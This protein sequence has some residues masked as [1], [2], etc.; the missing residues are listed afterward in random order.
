[1]ARK[2]EK[3]NGWANYETWNVALWFGNDYGM[4]QAVKEHGAKFT[5]ASAE[6]FTKE[7]LP[8]GTPDFESRGG[9]KCYAKVNW[10]EI[11]ADFNEMRG[12]SGV[13]EAPARG[14]LRTMEGVPLRE[15]GNIYWRDIPTGTRVELV[16]H[17]YVVTLG[18]G[19]KKGA[20]WEGREAREAQRTLDRWVAR[21]YSFGALPATGVRQH[22]GMYQQPQMRAAPSPSPSSGP[23]KDMRDH[24]IDQAV[25]KTRQSNVDHAVWMDSH[26]EFHVDQASTAPWK[27]TIAVAHAPS[28]HLSYKRHG[29]S[30]GVHEHPTRPLREHPYPPARRPGPRPLPRRRS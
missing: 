26:G 22:V 2:A 23:R 19:E 17:S 29:A 18:N 20:Y 28:G 15:M 21:G 11:A 3:Y 13:K 25:E 7:L 9:A 27:S 1:M 10:K 12:D 14:S 4:Y 5:A 8:N 24:A 16:G 30:E 6:E